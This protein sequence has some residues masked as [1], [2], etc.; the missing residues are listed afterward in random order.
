MAEEIKKDSG[1]SYYSG[2]ECIEK[3]ELAYGSEAVYWFCRC[4]AFK[5]NWRS[6]RKNNMQVVDSP[7]YYGGTECIDAMEIAF[8]VEAVYWFCRCNAFKYNWRG[9]KKKDQASATVDLGKA[10]WYTKKANELAIKMQSKGESDL[11]K[12]VWYLEKAN[13]LLKNTQEV[14]EKVIK[15]SKF[16]FL[17]NESSLE[18]IISNHPD[19]E[20]GDAY[21]AEDDGSMYI[22]INGWHI[23]SK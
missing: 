12:A 8:G 10:V 19:A 4:N 22:Y 1:L 3:M 14:K 18:S 15:G 7:S 2:T 11:E 5:Y 13:E 20:I 17:G 21:C 9:G 16:S 6:G 23:I